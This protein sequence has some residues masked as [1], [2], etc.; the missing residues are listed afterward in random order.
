V[1]GLQ[2]HEED[3]SFGIVPIFFSGKET[4]V[5]I[6]RHLSGYWGFPKGHPNP[7]ESELETAKRELFEESQLEVDR[8]LSEKM[9]VEKYSFRVDGKTIHKTVGYYIALVK[10][11]DTVIDTKEAREGKWVDINEAPMHLTFKEA[12]RICRESCQI[13]RDIN[14]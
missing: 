13:L 3:K 9:L 1:E 5:F 11:M 12:Q 2:D 7:K 14:H 10:S 8:V 4:L 6:L